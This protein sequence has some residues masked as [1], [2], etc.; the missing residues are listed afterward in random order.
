[1]L[2]STSITLLVEG[3]SPVCA[4]VSSARLGPTLSYVVFD[5]EHDGIGFSRALVTNF[6]EMPNLCP[7]LAKFRLTFSPLIQHQTMSCLVSFESL[8]ILLSNTIN[9][10]PISG[11]N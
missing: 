4:K 2:S 6:S 3:I 11:S 1:M 7:K 5:A 8:L 9:I 10:I